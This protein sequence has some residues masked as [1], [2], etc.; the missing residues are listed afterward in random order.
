MSSEYLIVIGAVAS[1]FMTEF[2]GISPGGVIVPG[3]VALFFPEPAR[4]LATIL[5]AAIAWGAVRLVS[6]YAILFG[7]RRY[8]AFILAGFLARFLVERLLPGLIP[9]APALAAVGWL[10]PGIIAQE[11][12]RQG[13]LRTLIAL[14]AAA[15][16]VRLT[17]TILA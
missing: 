13:P 11:A 5:D 10:V 15:L 6:R 1:L 9:E 14:A 3:Y 16:L 4:I 8:A 12:D 7:R 2:F 17:W